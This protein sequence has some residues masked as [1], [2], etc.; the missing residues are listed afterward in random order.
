MGCRRGSKENFVKTKPWVEAA[1]NYLAYGLAILIVGSLIAPVAISTG[2]KTQLNFTVL[3]LPVLTGLWVFKAAY[4]RDWSVLS[5]RPVTPL[6]ALV[7]AALLSFAAVNQP[8]V[9][10]A[11]LAPL[12]AQLGGLSVFVLSAALFIIAA[13]TLRDPRWLQVLT[14]LFLLLGATYIVG[15]LAWPVGDVV[16]PLYQKGATGSL[17]WTWLVALAF[18]QAAFNRRLNVVVRLALG[19]VVLA[20]LYTALTQGRDWVSGWLPPLVAIVTILWIGAPRLGGAVTVAG[21]ALVALYTPQ[22]LALVLSAD[23]QYSLKTRLAAWGVLGKIVA[24]SPALGF[25]PANYYH[26]TPLFPI[27]R[28]YVR[29][30][31]HNTYIDLLAQTGLIGCGCFVWFV[32][33][34]A[35]TGWSLRQQVP[36]GFAQA[37]AFGALGGLAGTLAAGMLCDWVLPFVYN[38]TLDGLR[39]SMV[40]WLFLGGLLALKRTAPTEGRHA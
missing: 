6:L 39:A 20:T 10:I 33:E 15:S 34:M 3:M 9:Y 35:R 14:G 11:P 31:S 25:G 18:G 16:L 23:N 13:D 29:F 37:Y 24:A 27:L 12:R 30:S 17:F 5:L 26:V 7:T 21:C 28:W 2:T 36:A 8:W 38:I 22:L 32:W 1:R 19:V 4:R 40:G